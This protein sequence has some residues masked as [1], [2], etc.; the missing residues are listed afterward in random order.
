MLVMALIISMPLSMPLLAQF[1]EPEQISPPGLSMN[2]PFIEVDK[3]CLSCIP[4]YLTFSAHSGSELYFG[5]T[6]LGG[7]DLIP[8]IL[9]PPGL[10]QL[11]HKQ[12]PLASVH[13][14][15]DL[16]VSPGQRGIF[17]TQSVASGFGVPVQ[18]DSGLGDAHSP[19]VTSLV[20]GTCLASWVETDSTGT[21]SEI[22]L[23]LSSD[24]PVSL[25]T[26]ERSQVSRLSGGVGAVLWNEGGQFR[27][28]V[29]DPLSLGPTLD[30]YDFGFTPSSWSAVTLLD[31]SIHLVAIE[32]MTLHFV[33]ANLLT[34]VITAVG[35]SRQ[36][37]AAVTDLSLDSVSQ[38]SWAA[39]WI[40]DQ[41]IILGRMEGGEVVVT[42]TGVQATEQ[43]MSLDFAGNAHLVTRNSE[44]VLYYQ[45]S[46][47][48]PEAN[49][50]ISTEGDGVAAH[51]IQFESLS[52]GMIT[53]QLWDFGDGQTSTEPSGTHVYTEPGQYYISLTVTGPGGVDV[54]QSPTPITVTAPDNYMMFAD[55]SVFGGQPVFHPVLGTHTDPLQGYQIGVE[56]DGTF[57]NMNE[58]S[59]SGTQAAQLSPEFIISNIFDDGA[60][61]SLY[62]AVIFDTLPPFDGRTVP[63]GINHTLCTLNYN[64]A[65]GLPLGSSTELR[66]ANGIG[67]PPINTIYAIDGGF[68]MEPYFIHGTV[69][70]SEQPQFLFVRGDATYDQSVNIADSIFMLDYLFIGG[71][72][73]V[74]PDAAD[75]NDDGI[76]N[77]GDAIYTLTY[78]FAN[79]ET[80]PYPYPG[81]GLDPTEDSL[82]A[83]LP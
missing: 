12:G 25:G 6:L 28:A 65:M 63:P 39:T 14:S 45:N 19:A 44:G 52:T 60:E 74:C 38:S 34:G 27:Y 69:L 16:P 9:T 57:L 32:G 72:A 51:E 5:G 71:P 33:S 8:V 35:N 7:N 20:D 13:M 22:F 42:N 79:G 64:V 41:E 48:A 62:L 26:G 53:G 70:V 10:G 73:S 58:V 24:P 61:S 37:G 30:L 47:P 50:S 17:V 76:L 55:I 36:S 18:Y 29:L 56:Y 40:Q 15:F 4:P 43:S 2:Q 54:Y 49:Y 80:I 75:A 23:R 1:S 21:T 83:C 46:I 66:F 77:I 67:F 82:G 11:V 59:I 31:G 68:A 78:L 81:Y 3:S